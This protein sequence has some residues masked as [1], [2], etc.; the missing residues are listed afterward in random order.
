MCKQVNKGSL[1]PTGFQ[2]YKICL[3]SMVGISFSLVRV[4]FFFLWVF[5]LVGPCIVHITK[6]S[7]SPTV[8]NFVLCERWKLILSLK[9]YDRI[10]NPNI[11]E[12]LDVIFQWKLYPDFFFGYSYIQILICRTRNVLLYYWRNSYMYLEY[13]YVWSKIGISV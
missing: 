9:Y 6:F 13:Y 11:C 4:L 7:F 10:F 5:G 3:W 1:S 12:F 2:T 8:Q